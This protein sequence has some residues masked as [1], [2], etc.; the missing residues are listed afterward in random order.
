MAQEPLSKQSKAVGAMATSDG[1][2]ACLYLHRVL[3]DDAPAPGIGPDQAHGVRE[4]AFAR[5]LNLYA[6]RLASMPP[7][8]RAERADPNAITLTFDDG[9]ADFRDLVLPHLER[10]GLRVVLFVVA[11]FPESNEAPVEYRLAALIARCRT[12]H[13][14]D[15]RAHPAATDAAR[16]A[17]YD[18]LWPS[19]KRRPPEDRERVLARLAHANGFESD[20]PPGPSMLDWPAIR[21]LDR[22]P[23]VEIGAHTARHPFLPSLRTPQVAAEI[24][25]GK[26]VL[27]RMLKHRVS[28]FAYPY[29]AAPRRA[30]WIVRLAGFDEAFGTGMAAAGDRFLRPRTAVSSYPEL[31]GGTPG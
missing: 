1:G 18:T 22:H 27:E 12:V 25:R 2:G 7:A 3:P 8:S 15:G 23:L 10:H 31:M 26:R 24:I 21:E 5:F 19:L 29:G 6:S 13:D 20:L 4:S 17:I 9:Y 16:Q 11:G 30:R 28:R 14:L